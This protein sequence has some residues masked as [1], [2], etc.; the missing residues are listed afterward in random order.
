[1]QTVINYKLNCRIRIIIGCW[2]TV[3]STILQPQTHTHTIPAFCRDPA[4]AGDDDAV[5]E[6]RQLEA[7]D[8][9]ALVAALLRAAR[10]YRLQARTVN[11]YRDC[12]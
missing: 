3:H 5:T 12:Y 10:R 1:M 4:R 2:Y 11:E 7:G 8:Y 9:G 6:G